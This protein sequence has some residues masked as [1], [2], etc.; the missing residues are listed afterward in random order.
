MQVGLR[1]TTTQ[2]DIADP[3]QSG[4]REAST[5]VPE[6]PNRNRGCSLFHPATHLQL[7]IGELEPLSEIQ[8]NRSLSEPESF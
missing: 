5:D 3:L 8:S 6:D 7:A 2:L 1:Q 4:L